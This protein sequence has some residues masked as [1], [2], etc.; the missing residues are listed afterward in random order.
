MTSESPDTVTIADTLAIYELTLNLRMRLEAHSASNAGASSVRL[1][2]RRQQLANGIEVDAISGHLTKHHHAFL[3]AEYFRDNGIPL[4]KNC[5]RGSSQRA[6][7]LTDGKGDMHTIMQQIVGECGIC[8]THGFLV[9]AKKEQP[10]ANGNA[11]PSKPRKR[12]KQSGPLPTPGRNRVNKD[13]VVQFAMGLAL[14][15]QFHEVE[16][17]YT[18]GGE[19]KAAGPMWFRRPVRSAEYAFSVCYKAA[20]IGMDTK[21]GDLVLT[22]QETRV[23]RHRDVLQVLRDMFLHP[24]GALAATQLPHLTGLVGAIAVRTRA[25]R[26][27]NWSALDPNFVA[28]LSDLADESC[29]VFTFDGPIRFAQVMNELITKSAPYIPQGA[30]LAAAVKRV[31]NSARKNS[32]KKVGYKENCGG[33]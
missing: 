20:A 33:K 7:G 2:P 13:S 25:G 4:C 32:G 8:D 6:T 15:D 9:P 24:V 10:E 22:D 31:S 5:A 12:R 29:Q 28:V 21:K 26:A 1:M 30:S 19:N 16:Q 18:R 23:A 3:L 11:A 27:P 17:L 14:P